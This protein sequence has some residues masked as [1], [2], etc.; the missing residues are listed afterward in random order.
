MGR[1]CQPATA[2]CREPNGRAVEKIKRL[3]R[4]GTNCDGSD[5]QPAATRRSQTT[6]RDGAIHRA[7]PGE[8][9][10]ERLRRRDLA[11]VNHE[12]APDRALYPTVALVRRVRPK[13]Q[14][15]MRAPFRGACGGHANASV[16]RPL[17]AANA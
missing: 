14:V 17:M 15:R 11:T 12:R 13:T 1:W 5:Q 4:V 3:A 6:A 8:R 9:E 10:V 16:D 7:E 2:P